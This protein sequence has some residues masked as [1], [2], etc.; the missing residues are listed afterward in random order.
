VPLFDS[1]TPTEINVR[2]RREIAAANNMPMK[3]KF[4]STPAKEYYNSTDLNVS[5][6]NL[7]FEGVNLNQTQ[8]KVNVTGTELILSGLPHYSEYHI[9][10]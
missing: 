4:T 6:K 8:G 10:V 9:T 1:E 5:T 2:F 3:R 7:T